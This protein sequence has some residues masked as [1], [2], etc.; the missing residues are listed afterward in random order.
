MTNS[1]RRTN[2]LQHLGLQSEVL[3]HV[4]AF[5]LAFAPQ[6]GPKQLEWQTSDK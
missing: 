3:K 6:V 4:M 1:R 2:R 5:R